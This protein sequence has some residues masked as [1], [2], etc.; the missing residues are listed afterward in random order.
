MTLRA[1]ALRVG[2]RQHGERCARVAWFPR[3]DALGYF[4]T[5]LRGEQVEIEKVCSSKQVAT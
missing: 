2:L 4:L 1:I 3:A 5:P